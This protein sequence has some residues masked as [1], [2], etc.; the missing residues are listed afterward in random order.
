MI[1]VKY[2]PGVDAG[3]ETEHLRQTAEPLSSFAGLD[4]LPVQRPA[5]IVNASAIG[6]APILLGASLMFASMVS[7]ALALG[8]S[9]RQRR[10]ELAILRTL[11]F[12]SGQLVGSLSWQ[13]SGLVAAGLVVGIPLGVV[14]GRSLWGIF[15]GQLSVVP[16]PD[17][18]VPLIVALVTAALLVANAAA[19]LYGRGVRR[20][21]PG[22][23]LRSQG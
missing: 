22:E 23:A 12:S 16:R 21:N 3:A 4:V 18:P 14:A 17:V 7:L 19:V 10:R 2:H 6:N 5:E 9:V 1:F 11:G 20:L 13:A 8:A 15:A